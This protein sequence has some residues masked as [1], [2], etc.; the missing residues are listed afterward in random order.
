MLLLHNAGWAVLPGADSC[1]EIILRS[2]FKK[3]LYG[4]KF[5]QTNQHY[6]W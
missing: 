5:A 2:Q 3:K 4:E 6:P 1:S